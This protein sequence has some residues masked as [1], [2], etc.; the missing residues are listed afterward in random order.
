MTAPAKSALRP[1]AVPPAGCTP[2]PGCVEPAVGVARD[3]A[4]VGLRELLQATD[5][6]DAADAADAGAHQPRPI[7]RAAW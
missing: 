1:A 4:A 7:C 3:L 5:A 2:W 6:A